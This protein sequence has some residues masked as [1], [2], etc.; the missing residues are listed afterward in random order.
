MKKYVVI[1]EERQDMDVKANN[2]YD[3]IQEAINAASAYY[4]TIVKNAKDNEVLTVSAIEIK[5]EGG[6]YSWE[7]TNV[8]YYADS[9]EGVEPDPTS[10]DVEFC[11][12]YVAF[13]GLLESVN[14]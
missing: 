12:S 14:D 3:T 10:C 7:P 4:E 5:K 1:V 11:L 6:E 2:S 9:V 13:D 8:L